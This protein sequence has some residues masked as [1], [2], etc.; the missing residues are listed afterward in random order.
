MAKF[1]GL[2][3][4]VALSQSYAMGSNQN[5]FC[6]TAKNVGKFIA[7]GTIPKHQKIA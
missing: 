6:N 2:V 3:L 4:G 1:V 5:P 7:Y